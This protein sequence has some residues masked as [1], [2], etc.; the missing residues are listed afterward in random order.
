MTMASQGDLPL[1]ALEE[2]MRRFYHTAEIDIGSSGVLDLTVDQLCALTGTELTELGPLPLHDSEPYGGHELRSALATRWT[3]GDPDPV[4]VTHGSSE[5]I[6]LI[7]NLAIQ[8]GETMIVVDP[9]YPQLAEIARWRGVNIVRWKLR[10]EDDFVPDLDMLEQLIRQCH[11]AMIVVN[12]P[13]N[14]TGTT[15]SADDQTRLI[16]LAS[17]SDAWLVWDHAFG[18]LTYE[19]PPLPIPWARAQKTISLGTLSKSY[20]L[21]G[22]RVGWVVAPTDLLRRMAVMRDYLALY[23]SPVL[24][25]FAAAAVQNAD[26]IVAKQRAH[27]QANRAL[28]LDWADAMG[29]Q[30]R[31]TRPL[32]GVS[33]AV[34]LPVGVEVEK[35]CT[36]LANQRVLLVPGASFGPSL[37]NHVRLGFGGPRT[38][39]ASGLQALAALLA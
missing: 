37:T 5:A 4:M 26:K 13:H 8:P 3:G 23:V 9:V 25:F 19:A 16:Q 11:P 30:I 35:L 33:A 32:G 15:I 14:P 31:V 10:V 27:A 34:G 6:W 17:D 2:W 36:T 12:F 24:E 18:E 7:M 28:L 38:D 20:G 22:L 21:P 1:A 39:L 29:D